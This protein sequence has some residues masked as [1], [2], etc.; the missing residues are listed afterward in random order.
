MNIFLRTSLIFFSIFLMG[1]LPL[2]GQGL[3]KGSL[4][5]FQ[6]SRGEYYFE[7]LQ[8]AVKNQPRNGKV[9]VESYLP[10]IGGKRIYK[11]V[12]EPVKGFVGMDTFRYS[13]VIPCSNTICFEE[14]EVQVKV[15]TSEVNALP[16]LFYVPVNAPETPLNVLRNDSGSSGSLSL[17]SVNTV[18]NGQASLA[19]GSPNILFKPK[20]GFT[21]V[22]QLIYTVCDPLGTCGQASV[23]IVVG[24][25]QPTGQDTLRIFTLRE[26]PVDVLVPNVYALLEKPANGA[27]EQNRDI[28]SY[29]PKA[30][31]TGSDYMVFSGR[32]SELTVEVVVLDVKRNSFAFDDKGNAVPGR[33]IELDVLAN[34]AYGMSASCVKFGKPVYGK[35][36]ENAGV[37]GLVTYE[38]PRGFIGVDE[39]TYTSFPPGCSGNSET[40]TV[41]VFVSNFEPSSSKFRMNTPMNTPLAI[42]YNIPINE[43]RF[44]L[45]RGARKGE[46]LLLNGLVDT[47]I[48]GTKIFGYNTLLYVPNP[49]TS[50]IDEF[51]VN[52]CLEGP[53]GQNC[54]YRKSVKI[55]V[56]ILP[57]TTGREMCFGDCVW[58]GD[59]NMDGI[60]N[61][62][63]LLPLGRFMGRV[64]HSRADANLDVWFGQYGKDWKNNIDLNNPDELKYADT[65][66][67]SIITADDTTAISRFY[68]RTHSL[69]PTKLPYADYE[70]RLE[71][72]L[73]SEPGKPVQLEILLGD[74][75]HPVTDL[76]GFTL[77]FSYNPFFFDASA[78]TIE[79]MNN[80]WLTYNAPVLSMSRNDGRGNV[81]AGFTRTNDVPAHGHGKV[82]R[83][84]VVVTVDIIGVSPPDSDG[85][86]HVPLFG[87][88]VATTTSGEKLAV[89]V[90][91]TILTIKTRPDALPGLTKENP[92]KRN[93]P[94]LLLFPN[95]SRDNVNVFKQGEDPLERIQV[96]SVSGQLIM[97][98][99]NISGHQYVIP[100]KEWLPGIYVA[101][102][103]VGNGEV[104]TRK[105]E[106]IR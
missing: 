103:K 104:I 81:S 17:R 31:F 82:G 80:S 68:G 69:V 44:D 85:N 87:N 12:Y 13:I 70:V 55:E 57:F 71:G 40:A 76:H 49:G 50:G 8:G 45:S 35:L 94:D 36:V 60:V 84:K 47:V 1:S 101:R 27:L 66:G 62:E 38:A 86:I 52:Y 83:S 51:E 90:K 22:S 2:S 37:N 67:N 65:D 73:F 48:F 54:Q 92:V 11:L 78:S 58:A 34:D 105:I 41:R 63:D 23:S 32:G 97:D 25:V 46:V 74:E 96:F 64:G 14:W 16:D 6:D 42:G 19:A 75:N 59:T 106:V 91:P 18:N 100:V 7:A 4:L 26:E 61:M 99:G 98:S 43:F 24:Q 30:G 20:T 21:G 33:A 15:I 93:G 9:W 95:P 88:A 5:V 29:R 102:V 53:D 77:D 39:F 79:F 10:G 72:D 89:R 56:D 3:K 28:P